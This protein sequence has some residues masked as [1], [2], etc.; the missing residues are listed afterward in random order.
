MIDAAGPFVLI[1]I[2]GRGGLATHEFV[3]FEACKAA[4]VQLEPLSHHILTT[5]CIAAQ[6]ITDRENQDD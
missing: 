3:S 5:H 1:L 6:T 2:L 4:Q